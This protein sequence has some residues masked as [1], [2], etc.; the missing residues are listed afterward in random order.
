MVK[1]TGRTRGV[2]YLKA[3]LDYLTRNG[4]LLAETRDG[5][6]FQDRKRLRELH[7]EWLLANA[8][9]ARGRN[10]PQATQ[11]VGIILSMPAGAPRDRVREHQEV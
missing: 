8:A 11:S 5:D 2:T 6:Q 9:E 10:N 7:D 1:V 3:H 4:K